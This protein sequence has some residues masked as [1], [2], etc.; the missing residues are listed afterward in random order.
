MSIPMEVIQ[1][2]S[3]TIYDDTAD[4]RELINDIEEYNE[5]MRK[6]Q[7]KM[8]WL[9][10]IKYIYLAVNFFIVGRA[11]LHN[12]FA[13]F[14]NST[15]GIIIILIN[16]A[17]YIIFA[18]IKGK[19]ILSTASSAL[20]IFISRK[21]AFLFLVNLIILVIHEFLE[22]PLKAH[23]G[24]PNFAFIL[25]KYEQGRHIRLDWDDQEY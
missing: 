1:N 15:V 6:C 18:L 4:R 25:V 16:I 23:I 21:M 2:G 13:F 5:E 11:F 17:V 7:K 10:E 8:E 3:I 22:R 12:A 20:Y 14:L 9:D 24:Y 19:F